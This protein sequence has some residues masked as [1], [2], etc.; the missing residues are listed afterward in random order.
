M[1]TRFGS[2]NDIN[3]DIDLNEIHS[4]LFFYKSGLI[5]FMVS[6]H[7]NTSFSSESQRISR[8]N[9]SNYIKPGF[10]NVVYF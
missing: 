5:Q 7:A 3:I 9:T 4:I 1:N 6:L 2:T 8:Y 10:N